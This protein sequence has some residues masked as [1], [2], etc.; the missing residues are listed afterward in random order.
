VGINATDIKKL[1][2]H[3]PHATASSATALRE[4]QAVAASADSTKA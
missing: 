2:E 3:G 1:K 4:K